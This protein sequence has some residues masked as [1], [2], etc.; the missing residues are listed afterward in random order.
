MKLF[1]IIRRS[2]IS[3]LVIILCQQVFAQH[4]EVAEKPTLWKGKEKV[5]AD[6]ASLL[7]AFKNGQMHGHFR[8][9]FMATDNRNDLSDYYA[10]AAGGGIKYETAK[11]YGF[12][13]GVSS[14]FIFNIWSSDLSKPDPKTNQQNRYELGLFD[15][16]NPANKTDIDRL[17]EF[18]VKYSWKKFQITF[19]KQLINTPFINLQDGRMRPTA[20]GG[21][22]S[23]IYALKNTRI[24]GGYLYEISPRSTVKWYGVGASVGVYPQG[25]NIDGL[26][27]DYKGNLN[28]NGMALL[29]VSHKWNE[30]FSIQL[31]NLYAANIFN[32][33]LLQADYSILLEN[34]SK[35]IAALQYIKQDAVKDGGNKNPAKTYFCKNG[36]SQSF[37]IKLGWEN[38]RIQTSVNYNRITAQGRYLMPREW[39]REPFFTF[40]PRERNEGLGDVNAFLLKGG[41]IF[42]D[43][44]IKLQTGIGYYSLPDVNNYRLNKYGLPSYTQI[45]IDIRHEFAGFLKGMEAQL[46]FVYKG[47]C[48]N[49]YGNE[50]YVINKVDVCSWNF[51]LNYH[52]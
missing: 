32:S 31:H 42:P 38:K 37:G 24:A 45:N 27:S 20:A 13:I 48:G 4:Q 50:K 21:I 34:K 52:F 49:V 9:F 11:L 43:A 44:G 8:Y 23:E 5:A 39:G 10:N 25:V 12:Q 36:K 22:Y 29:G 17:E 28:S 1:F 18:Y 14:F 3:S 15:V 41:Y 40:L 26:K 35:V 6:S 51:M 2:F 19:G 7:H 30:N 16:A 47:K 33:A 46:L